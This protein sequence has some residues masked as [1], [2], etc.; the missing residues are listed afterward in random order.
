MSEWE[1]I[2]DEQHEPVSKRKIPGGYLYL[3]Y[4]H[5]YEASGR[6]APPSVA[7]C[8]VPDQSKEIK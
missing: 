3:Y 8:F 7:M 6:S 4:Q 5:N 1:R 2:T